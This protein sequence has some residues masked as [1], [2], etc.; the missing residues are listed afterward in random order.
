[1]DTTEVGKAKQK[2]ENTNKLTE[3]N[4]TNQQT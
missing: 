3:H 2:K 4:I 1:M